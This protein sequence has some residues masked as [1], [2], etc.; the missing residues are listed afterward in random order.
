M[1]KYAVV[2][3]T[4]NRCK[5]LEENIAALLQQTL[6]KFSIFIVDNA[7]TDS[8][9][10]VVESFK[11]SRLMYYNTGKNLG[12]AGGFAFGV[13]QAIINNYDYAWIMDDDSVPDKEA[14]KSLADKAD[15]ID[16][17]FSFFA[18]LVYWVDGQIFP[19]NTPSANWDKAIDRDFDLLRKKKLLRINDGSFVGCFINLSVAKSV[20]L[21]ISDFFIYGD[22]LEYT[23]RLAKI[24]KAYLDVDS[25]IVHK[26][27]SNVGA[28]V[29]TASDDYIG[30]FFFQYRNGMYIRRRYGGVHRFVFFTLKQILKILLYSKTSKLKRIAMVVK[31]FVFGFFYNPEIDYVLSGDKI[32]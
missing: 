18:S 6:E 8:T 24:E 17:K 20:G 21:P 14:L 19:M 29:V 28:D 25:I 10:S 11:D 13:K 3:V 4:Y 12:G 31:G 26:A 22:D 23:Y 7:S 1:K 16:D 15:S 30:R 9:K 5:L 27:P 2:V 32:L